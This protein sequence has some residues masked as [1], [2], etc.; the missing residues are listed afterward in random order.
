MMVLLENIDLLIVIILLIL[1]V[2]ISI[3]NFLVIPSQKRQEKILLWMIH[4][5]EMAEK[6]YGSKT[7]KLKLAYVY[8]QFLER[9]G[10]LGLFMSQEVFETLVNR[11][12][13]IMEEALGKK[14]NET[15]K[16]QTE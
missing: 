15:T 14:L 7:G 1:S 12:I 3:R 8:Q 11:A 13:A 16:K 10:I 9:F 2:F 5:V 6:I 4:N